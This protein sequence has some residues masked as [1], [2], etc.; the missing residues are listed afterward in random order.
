MRQLLG[1][2]FGPADG[3]VLVREPALLG[4]LT[5]SV[6]TLLAGIVVWFVARRFSHRNPLAHRELSRLGSWLSWSAFAS[7]VLCFFFFE[8]AFNRRFLLYA[9][10][11]WLWILIGYAIYHL[12][13]GYPAL[14]R[15][16]EA[17]R[18]RRRKYVPAPSSL[19]SRSTADM[20]SQGESMVRTRRRSS[21]RTRAR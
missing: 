6:A 15:A 2:L 20:A 16:Q 8:N 17:E 18:E 21:R 10:L 5:L 12:L 13:T 4:I 14:Q 7:L 11:I 3:G 1:Y 9:M 19:A